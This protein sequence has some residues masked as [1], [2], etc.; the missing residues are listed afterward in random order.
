[1]ALT[2]DLSVSVRKMIL[3]T[4]SVSMQDVKKTWYESY[5]SYVPCVCGYRG[6]CKQGVVISS[7]LNEGLIFV[8]CCSDINFPQ[9]ECTIY[10]NVGVVVMFY[11]KSCF[12]IL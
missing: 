7:F 2:K 10:S 8:Q 11:T 3:L 9:I 4:R 6:P 5:D 12:H 1:M